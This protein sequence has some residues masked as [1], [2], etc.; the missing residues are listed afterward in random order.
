MKKVLVL[1]A[2][3]VS[4]PLIKYLT[5]RQISV[6][7]ASKEFL[8]TEFLEKNSLVETH[9]LDLNDKTSLE[10]LVK[11]HDLTVSLLPYKFHVEIANLCILHKKNMLTASYVSEE[12]QKLDEKAKE[13]G[14]ILMNE[15]GLDPGIDHMSAMQ[16]ID[17]VQE[18][19][20]EVTSFISNCGGL[21]LWDAISTPF[22]YKFSWSPEGVILA[23]K[24]SAQYLEDGHVVNI[25][26]NKVFS[27]YKKYDLEQF[28]QYEV[29]PNRDSLK[30][31]DLYN[32]NGVKTMYRGTFRNNDWCDTF[33][34]LLE[35]NLLDQKQKHNLQEKTYRQFMKDFL[36]LESEEEFEKLIAKK[37][38][39]NI[40]AK[41]LNKIEW[42]GLFSNE[43]IGI[44]E[45]TAFDI[46]TKLMK[47]KLQ[48]SEDE[49]D[50]V[51]LQHE[52][53]VKFEDRNESIQSLLLVKGEK[54]GDS[55]MAKTV[56][57]PAAIVTKLILDN[58][59]SLK[60]VQI[61]TKKEIYEP[62]IKELEKFDIQFLEKKT[63]QYDWK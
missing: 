54:N 10:N 63:V 39:F 32:L 41:V 30:Y 56:G 35:N 3:L 7:V 1:G 42:L 8:N 58:E 17:E 2:G 31:I 59:I 34:A 46:I 4:K 15:I 19:G 44:D 26:A 6:T 43:K 53:E 14:I 21:P 28:G 11:V 16:M 49:R 48:Y 9:T 22:K 40:H 61:P 60:G 18:N 57:L 24:N 47:D 36:G 20:G 23:A 37:L 27:Y 38:G 55:A 45:G 62:A 5:D 51:L 33:T 13:A 29:Y 50:L 25:P 12:M 52:F